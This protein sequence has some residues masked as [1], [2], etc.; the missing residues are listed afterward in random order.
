MAVRNGRAL[1][2]TYRF[3]IWKISGNKLRRLSLEFKARDR[4][5]FPDRLPDGLWKF[6]STL[7]ALEEL[8]LQMHPRQAYWHFSHFGSLFSLTLPHLRKLSIGSSIFTVGDTHY[9]RLRA[10]FRTHHLLEEVYFPGD[11][12]GDFIHSFS[13]K[14]FPN[15]RKMAVMRNLLTNLPNKVLD[16]L[17]ELELLTQRVVFN[18]HLQDISNALVMV[19]GTRRLKLNVLLTEKRES[20]DLVQLI[21]GALPVLEELE[22]FSPFKYYL[23]GAAMFS[24]VSAFHPEYYS[25]LPLCYDMSC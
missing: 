12:Y 13:S 11:P 2:T 20:G 23:A 15:V 4:Y 6:L 9:Y 10:F 18:W 25:D 17:Q 7:K 21:L 5:A 1:L 14:A 22:I 16:Q 8:S 3:Q 19:K 24:I